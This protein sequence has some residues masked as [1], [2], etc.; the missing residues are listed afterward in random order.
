[1][2]PLKFIMFSLSSFLDDLSSL[3]L[4]DIVLFSSLSSTLAFSAMSYLAKS[5]SFSSSSFFIFSSCLS[6][7]FSVLV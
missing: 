1:M 5:E 2:Y 7:N 4:D 3:S 6:N